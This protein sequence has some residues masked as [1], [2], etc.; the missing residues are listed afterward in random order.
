MQIDIVPFDKSYQTLPYT[1]K[2]IDGTYLDDFENIR[3]R[4]IN[5]D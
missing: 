5:A 4:G 1:L 3:I 2:P